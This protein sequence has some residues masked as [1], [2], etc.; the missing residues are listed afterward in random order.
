[1]NADHKV[2]KNHYQPEAQAHIIP[3]A[4]LDPETMALLVKCCPAGLYHIM[5]D[6][7]LRVDV[8]GCLE[9][10]TCRMLV[11]E[12]ALKLWRYPAADYGIHLRFG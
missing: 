1:M 4:N 8:H 10:G 2:A 12:Q 7:S 3:A 9:C 11:D 5:G 6:G